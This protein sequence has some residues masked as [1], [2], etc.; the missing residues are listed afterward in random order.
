MS[1]SCVASNGVLYCML[2]VVVMCV[3][4]DS[5]WSQSIQQSPFRAAY[6]ASDLSAGASKLLLLVGMLC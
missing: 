2:M 4:V 5:I 6:G 3:D 1:I